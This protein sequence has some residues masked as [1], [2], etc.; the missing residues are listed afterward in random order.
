[1]ADTHADARCTVSDR[2][3][4]LVLAQYTAY[5][6]LKTVGFATPFVVVFLVGNGV[7]YTDIALGTTAMAVVMIASEIPSGYVGDRFGRRNTILVG[8]TF[9]ALGAT[10]YLVGTSTASVVLL[11]V[12]FGLSAAIQSG[13]GD[14]WFYD[15]LVEHDAEDRYTEFASRVG[16]VVKYASAATMLAG[17]GLFLVQPAYAIGAGAGASWL[18]LPVIATLP[19]NDPDVVEQLDVDEANESADEPLSIRRAAGSVREFLTNPAVRTVAL[20]QSLYFGTM[21]ANSKY[22]QPTT[23]EVL[24][25][26]GLTVAAVAIPT[27]VVL[28]TVYALTSTVSGFVVRFGKTAESY[29]GVPATIALPYAAGAVCMLV[30]FVAPKFAL[31]AMVGFLSIPMLAGPTKSAYLNDHMESATRATTGSTISFVMAIVRIPI[32]LA[33]GMLADAVSPRFAMAALGASVLVAGGVVLLVDWPLTISVTE[34]TGVA[35]DGDP[36]ADDYL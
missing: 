26:G 3:V 36:T 5:R 30:P 1:M 35:A 12:A 22:V 2:A 14:A 29:L 24:P 34:T 31:P 27:A 20:L 18:A 6:S 25:A 16:S 33:G 11:Y 23:F 17:A 4:R 9:G 7:T 21:L 13:S 8:Q 15:K 10:G 32:L 19:T 28:A